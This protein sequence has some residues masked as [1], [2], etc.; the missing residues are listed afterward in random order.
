MDVKPKKHCKHGRRPDGKCRKIK[1]GNLGWG[2]PDAPGGGV[3]NPGQIA[4]PGES[5]LR[6]FVRSILSEIELEDSLLYAGGEPEVGMISYSHY[7]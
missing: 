1:K 2:N 3:S 6:D 5:V 4:S 7:L